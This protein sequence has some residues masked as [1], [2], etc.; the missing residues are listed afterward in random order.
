M[1]FFDFF[2]QPD[3]NQ[4][5]KDYQA[6][7]SAVLLDVRTPQEY[8]EGRIPGSRN[9]PLQTIDRVP[10]VVQNKD[11]PLFVYCYSGA[12]SRQAVGMLQRMGYTNVTNIGGIA[13]YS[14]KVEQ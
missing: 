14:G 10:S 4:G 13:A 11:I 6:A 9:I 7:P 8:R 5:V 3:I 1:G 12:R 2:R